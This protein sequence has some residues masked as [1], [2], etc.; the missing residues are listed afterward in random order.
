MVIAYYPGAGGNRYIQMLLGNSWTKSNVSYDYTNPGHEYKYKY[1]LGANPEPK[2][3]YTLTHCM[4]CKKIIDQLQ[5]SNIT[6]IKTDLQQSLRREWLLHGHK[7]YLNQKINSTLNRVEHYQA[8]KDSNWPDVDT[9]D[10]LN[11]L[12]YYILDEVNNDY[13]KITSFDVPSVLEQ[14]TQEYIDKIN[15]AYETIVWHRDYYEKFP[16]DFTGAGTVIDVDSGNDKF[17]VVMRQELSGYQC[18]VFDSVWDKV[19]NG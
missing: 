12:P 9:V 19:Y 4:N 2:S 16:V 6:V 11:Q 15:S 8:F 7:N 17:S 13:K 14:L 3:G 5:C 10:Q 18:K 1:L